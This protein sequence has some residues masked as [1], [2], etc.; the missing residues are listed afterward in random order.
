MPRSRVRRETWDRP[1][2]VTSNQEVGLSI[3]P[4]AITPGQIEVRFPAFG[5]GMDERRRIN[6]L[7]SRRAMKAMRSLDVITSTTTIGRTLSI[8]VSI[9]HNYFWSPVRHHP[10]T[11]WTGL[12]PHIFLVFFWELLGDGRHIPVE[13]N[14]L[15][16]C[17]GGEAIFFSP[18]VVLFFAVL[19]HLVLYTYTIESHASSIFI[20]RGI[21]TFNMAL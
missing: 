19:S 10:T 5:D 21:Y 9:N 6:L 12:F 18:L 7:A 4:F 17:V 16:I 20:L 3:P 11:S 14:T 15:T 13:T 1:S 2:P 8:Y